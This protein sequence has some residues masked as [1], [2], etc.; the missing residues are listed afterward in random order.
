MLRDGQVAE[1][2]SRADVAAA[3]S[4]ALGLHVRVGE[5]G[6][7]VIPGHSGTARLFRRSDGREWKY[8]CDCDAREHAVP[9]I[10]AAI[11]A[12]GPPEQLRGL[13][14]AVWYRRLLHEAGLLD[15]IEVALPELA[16][17]AHPVTVA[18]RAGFALLVG[19]RHVTHPG[20][21]VTYT[22]AFARA[23]SG[24]RESET[25][26]YGHI[27]RLRNARVIVPAGT[28]GRA[29]LF[30][31]G[32][33]QPAAPSTDSRRRSAP[34]EMQEPREPRTLD[35]VLPLATPDEQTLYDRVV[36][37]SASEGA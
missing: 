9:D 36:A 14:F 1:L 10:R 12:G 22:R 34:R 29:T 24:L 28:H 27:G 19:L 13:L 8:R 7:C 11:G 23:W 37:M 31:P 30:E 33:V 17:S 20:Q 16:T 2:A 21:P 3:L 35:H 5:A 6:T 18:L 32:A 4:A 25:T 26:V 15:P